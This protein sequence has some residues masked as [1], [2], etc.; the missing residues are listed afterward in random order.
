MLAMISVVVLLH[1][2]HHYWQ[3]LEM[4]LLLNKKNKTKNIEIA[5]PEDSKHCMFPELYGLLPNFT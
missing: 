5:T 1:Y 3:C 4:W 2:Y